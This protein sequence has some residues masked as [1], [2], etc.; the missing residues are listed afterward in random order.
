M[1]R[2]S[3]VKR[4]TKETVIEAHLN[5]DGD[6]KCEVDTQI[7]F[8]DHMLTSM[9][10]HALFDLSIKAKGDLHVDDH[11]TV[12]DVGIVLGEAFNKALKTK[13]R[14]Q[15]FANAMVPMDESL[16]QVAVDLSGRAHLE[17]LVKCKRKKIGSFDLT[18]MHEFFHALSQTGMFT[19][20]I[21][22]I[23]G[24]NPHHIYESIFKAVG[25]ALGDASRINPRVKGIPSTKGKL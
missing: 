5:I 8:F 21:E 18:L 3:T 15:R 7:G 14:I 1:R 23:H 20:H 16:A 2:T 6:G 19:L 4:K 17:Y 9:Y 10:K 25:R 11:H 13:Q 22:L 12:E 24:Q